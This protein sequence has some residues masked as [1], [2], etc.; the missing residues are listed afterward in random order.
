MISDKLLQ[1]TATL[2]PWI[3]NIIASREQHAPFLFV[4]DDSN[5]INIISLSLS[6]EVKQ[7]FK[8]TLVKFLRLCNAQGYIMI[9]E[10]WI[11]TMDKDN[12]LLKSIENGEIKVID[13][14]LD[15]RKEVIML[16]SVDR[17]GNIQTEMADIKDTIDKRE[18]GV[19]NTLTSQFEG[20]MIVTQW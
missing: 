17:E 5:H 9:M 1:I 2:K 3:Y 18:L 10:S 8:S 15:D 4:L 7:T 20:R 13:L 14:P 12:S 19:F 11:T 6:E 16:I